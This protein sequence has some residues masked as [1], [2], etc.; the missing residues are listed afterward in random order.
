MSLAFAPPMGG[1]S[2]RIHPSERRRVYTVCAWTQRP[3]HVLCPFCE[4]AA[5]HR[6]G[7]DR[8]CQCGSVTVIEKKFRFYN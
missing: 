8:G 6:E 3:L 4:S 1:A 5:A 2:P 7:Y